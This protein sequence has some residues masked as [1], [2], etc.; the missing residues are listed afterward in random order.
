MIRTVVKLKI[1]QRKCDVIIGVGLIFVIFNKDD[2]DKASGYY[3]KIFVDSFIDVGR[4]GLG[5]RNWIFGT[6]TGSQTKYAN[7]DCR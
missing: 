1:K 4:S 6:P 3:T 7:Q 2:Y 5:Q